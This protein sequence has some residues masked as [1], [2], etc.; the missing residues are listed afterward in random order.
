[1]DFL[2][3]PTW[4]AGKEMGSLRGSP[5]QG[6]HPPEDK[7]TWEGKCCVITSQLGVDALVYTGLHGA[8]P[9]PGWAKHHCT[10][11]PGYAQ[12]C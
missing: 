7:L 8:D 1:M 12:F 6:S 11:Q 9:E 10:C 3:E 4:E 5:L 2:E